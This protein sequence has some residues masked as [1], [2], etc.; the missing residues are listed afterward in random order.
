[1][2]LISVRINKTIIAAIPNKG[3]LFIRR[4]RG[5]TCKNELQFGM[6]TLKGYDMDLPG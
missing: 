5:T 4:K 1:M 3:I 6:L 2:Y